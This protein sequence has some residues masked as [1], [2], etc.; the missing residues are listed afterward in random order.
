MLSELD[1]PSGVVVG[2]ALDGQ[3]RPVLLEGY[4]YRETA[5]PGFTNLLGD[6][7]LMFS[8]TESDTLRNIAKNYGI[9][10]LVARPGTD[11]ALPRPLPPWLVQ[12][13]NTGD[14][15]IYKID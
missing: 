7:E 12:Q 8:T 1:R 10:W 4:G 14:L 2:E 3:E 9:R 11:I 15:H 6:N 5:L 13:Q